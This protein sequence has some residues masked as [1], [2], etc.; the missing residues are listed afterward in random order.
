MG[1]YERLLTRIVHGKSDTE[2]AF[3]NLC[4]LLEWLGFAAR[5]WG[6]HHMYR[7]EGITE[8]INLQKEG[9][10][11]KPY[12]VRQVRNIILKYKLGDR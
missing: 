8:K 12:Q 9:G 2:I 1:K 3:A 11:A 4:Y 10:K 7:K 6:G 5:V